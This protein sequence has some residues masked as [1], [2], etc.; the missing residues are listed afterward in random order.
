MEETAF[1]SD[2]DTN[3]K[4]SLYINYQLNALIIIYS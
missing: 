3:K 4:S 1:L 2:K